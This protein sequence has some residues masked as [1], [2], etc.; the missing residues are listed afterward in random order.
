MSQ[1]L[2]TIALPLTQTPALGITAAQVIKAA[3]GFLGPIF[4]SVVGSAG[5]LTLNDANVLVTAQTITGITAANPA[6]ITISTVSTT[7]PFALGNPVLVTS[8]GG[9]T[10][11][12]GVL[13]TVT[14]IGGSSGAWTVTTNINASAFSAWTTGGTCASFGAGNQILT[15]AYTAMTAGTII[16][17]T[18]DLKFNNGLLVSGV[19]SAGS[20]VF[21]LWYN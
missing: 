7:N 18:Q 2:G 13:G 20:P 5:S 12:N 6:V 4:P 8:A 10:Q 1:N 3:A 21:S 16:N 19:P 11:I 14:A 15:L 17:P 9:M